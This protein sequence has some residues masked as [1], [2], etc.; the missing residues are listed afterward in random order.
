MGLQDV[1]ST[2]LV[3]S[4]ALPP[5]PVGAPGWIGMLGDVESQAFGALYPVTDVADPSAAIA[6][7]LGVLRI[8]PVPSCASTGKAKEAITPAMAAV[9]AISLAK[10][11]LIAAVPWRTGARW[12]PRES[13]IAQA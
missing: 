13:S 11:C 10:G 12:L 7:R 3:P 9:R 5:R 4:V 8:G 1:P 2:L 6:A